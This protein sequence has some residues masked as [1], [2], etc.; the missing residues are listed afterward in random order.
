M[1]APDVVGIPIKPFGIA[2]ARLG[3]ALDASARAAMGMAI[4]AHTARTVAESGAT[5]AIVTADDGVA[6]WARSHGWAVIAEP[7]GG[8]LDGAAAAVV[9]MAIP[10]TWAVLHADLPTLTVD[11]LVAAWPH[12]LSAGVIAPSRDGGTVLVGGSRRIEFSYGRGSFQRHLRR[13]PDATIVVRPGLALDLDT[14]ADLAAA[15]RRDAG[16]WLR[17]H[18]PA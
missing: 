10:G 9:D 11:D 15:L 3:P 8:G 6:R 5:P 12:T 1:S 2:K 7:P 18:V 17:R 16:A 14:P 13:M 4:G